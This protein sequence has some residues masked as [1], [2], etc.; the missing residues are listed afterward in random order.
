MHCCF[1]R[2]RCSVMVSTTRSL[3]CMYNNALHNCQM[4]T[5]SLWKEKATGFEGVFLQGHQL[6][7][8]K[9]CELLVYSEICKRVSN[10][11]RFVVARICM[12][13]LV[14]SALQ[15]GRFCGSFYC[16]FISFP[17]N[18]FEAIWRRQSVIVSLMVCRSFC[19]ESLPLYVDVYLYL[20]L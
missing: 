11:C 18:S 13:E 5:R 12:P 20:F 16:P 7:A 19:L 17:R 4:V 1:L 14:A 3:L 10:C 6:H 15:T 9:L 8:R 2:H